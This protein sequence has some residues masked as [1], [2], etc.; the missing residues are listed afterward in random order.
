MSRW[1]GFVLYLATS[2]PIVFRKT[3]APVDAAIRQFAILF[4]FNHDFQF[5][6]KVR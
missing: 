6:I 2:I 5:A 3:F 1:Q 4:Y